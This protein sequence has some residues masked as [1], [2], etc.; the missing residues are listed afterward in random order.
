MNRRNL[1]SVAGTGAIGIVGI[2]GNGIAQSGDFSIQLTGPVTHQSS[3]TGELIT[4]RHSLEI[5][6]DR[7]ISLGGD[8]DRFV[9][10]RNED[11]GSDVLIIPDQEFTGVEK[12]SLQNVVGND[13]QLEPEKNNLVLDVDG[14]FTTD[15]AFSIEGDADTYESGGVFSSFSVAIVEGRSSPTVLAET[16]SKLRGVGWQRS[17]LIQQ[18]TTGSAEISFAPIDPSLNESWYVEF[19]MFNDDVTKTLIGPT[20]FDNNGDNITG[21]IDISGLTPGEYNRWYFDVYPSKAQT[22]SPDSIIG[23]YGTFGKPVVVE[24]G[25]SNDSAE[26]E[27]RNIDITPEAVDGTNENHTLTFDVA[28]LSADDEKDDFTITMPSEV[29]VNGVAITEAPGLDPVPDDPVPQNQIT[30]TVDPESSVQNPVNM[31]VELDLSPST[32]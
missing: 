17:Q 24:S 22:D 7:K 16:D 20:E 13:R 15:V 12:V 18:G 19:E 10:V 25:E 28:N 4:A 5:D 8:S 11:T 26:V 29:N 23:G 30:F 9:Q 21:T 2:S 14:E 32:D 27:L 1:L 3:G 6:I 31:T